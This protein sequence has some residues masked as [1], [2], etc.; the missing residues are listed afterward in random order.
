M[1][2]R[3][4]DLLCVSKVSLMCYIPVRIYINACV[5]NSGNYAFI[6]T[7]N[8]IDCTV[9]NAPYLNGLPCGMPPK[10]TLSLPYS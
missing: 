3:Y 1:S 10:Q 8:L 6:H 5:V 2:I 7:L 4:C 9:S